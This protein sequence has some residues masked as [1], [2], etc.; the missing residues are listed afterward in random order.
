MRTFKVES[1]V[2]GWSGYV[3]CKFLG[4]DEKFELHSKYADNISQAK[5]M[6]EVCQFVCEHKIIEVNIR[7]EELGIHC[8]SVQDL[9][10]NPELHEF[11]M[12]CVMRVFTN[13]VK[14]K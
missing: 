3:V 4:F 8:K 14:G 2:A 5:S 6:L 10:E 1:E 12:A 11:L 9:K 7:S 13:N